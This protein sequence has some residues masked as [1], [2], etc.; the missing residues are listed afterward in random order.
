M[1]FN[2]EQLFPSN[3]SDE[4]LYPISRM[5][6]RTIDWISMTAVVVTSPATRARPVLTS[7]STATRD[8]GS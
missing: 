7:V 1:A 5:T 8:L 3:P 4:P 2:T 6:P